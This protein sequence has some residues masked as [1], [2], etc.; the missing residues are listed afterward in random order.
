MQMIRDFSQ[1][2]KTRQGLTSL[3]L[4]LS[5]ALV[6]ELFVG[7]TSI[8]PLP[9]QY[10]PAFGPAQWI[11]KPDADSSQAAY[12]RKSLYIE[13][14]VQQAWIQIAATGNYE[15]YINGVLLDQRTY[16]SVRLTGAYDIKTLLSTGNNVIAVYVAA[17]TFPGPSQI[18]VRGA[19]TTASSPVREFYSDST[20]KV[21]WTPDGVVGGERWYSRYLVDTLWS[22][23]KEI[24]PDA[25]D[26]T[27]QPLAFDPAE[28]EGLP[29]AKWIAAGKV[30]AKE[31]SFSHSFQLPI[32]R[33]ETWLQVAANGA[34]DVIVNGQLAA[35]QASSAR[36]DRKQWSRLRCG[37][38][39]SSSLRSPARPA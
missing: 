38:P 15:L 14:S 16:P 22:E 31:V 20:W 9:K 27:L 17:G 5:C 29:S 7:R 1:Y 39:T 4:V 35:A 30:T 2:L 36:R 13:S 18:R 21:S 11:Q 8:C 37:P 28:V 25:Q 26:S 12:F 33:G 32:F 6:L 10:Y 23:A 34:Y 3:F 24:G 19:C